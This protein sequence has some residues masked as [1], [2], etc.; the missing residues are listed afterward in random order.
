MQEIEDSI[1]NKKK[2]IYMILLFLIVSGVIFHYVTSSKH[3]EVYLMYKGDDF[4]KRT[5]N[6]EIFYSLKKDQKIIELQSISGSKQE[7]ELIYLD[8]IEIM[9][10]DSFFNIIPYSYQEIALWNKD[11]RSLY[12]RI[13]FF[14]VETD[15][16]NEKL[17]INEVYLPFIEYD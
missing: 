9:K 17:V 4:Y 7:K 13:K 15:S 10:L 11:K 8:N 12:E 5:S 16:I 1:V 2:Y 6:N 3:D 14:V